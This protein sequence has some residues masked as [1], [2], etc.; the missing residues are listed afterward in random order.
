MS[1][2]I[3]LS[4]V[5]WFAVLKLFN[6]LFVRGFIAPITAIILYTLLNQLLSPAYAYL[7]KRQNGNYYPKTKNPNKRTI[8]ELT[9]SNDRKW[10]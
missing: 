8:E 1:L 5:F 10:Y 9:R 6:N 4:F 2:S 7:T 3:L